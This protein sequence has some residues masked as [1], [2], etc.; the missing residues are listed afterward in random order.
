MLL[1][2]FYE[3]WTGGLPKWQALRAAQREVRD[4]VRYGHPFHWAGFVLVG[5]GR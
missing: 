2:R 3:H 5:D 1:R 4:D